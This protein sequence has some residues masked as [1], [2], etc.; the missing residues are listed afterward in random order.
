MSADKSSFP[1]SG[2]IALAGVIA[3]GL[4]V[5]LARAPYPVSR[6]EFRAY[7]PL[8]VMAGSALV[9]LVALWWWHRHVGSS[10][11]LL[12]WTRRLNRNDGVASA[13]QIWRVAGRRAMRKKMTILRPSLKE[14]PWWRRMLVPTRELASPVARV[15]WVRVWSPIED[16][17]LRVGG[18]RSGKSGEMAGRIADAPG[19]AIVTSTRTDL[20]ELTSALRAE[21]GPV[22]VFN[23]AGLAGLESTITFDPL[24]GCKYATTAND[25]AA[26]LLA[27]ASAPGAGGDREFWSDQA[28][29]TL[30]ALLHAAALDGLSMQDVLGWV[31]DPDAGAAEITRALRRSEVKSFEPA[32]VQFLNTNDRTRSSICATI[33]PALGWLTNATAAAAAA[34]GNVFDVERLIAERGTVYMLGAEE[35]QTAPLVTAL[36][37]HIAREGRR[38]AANQPG[39]RLDPPLSLELD[40]AAIISPIP[41]P[42]LTADMGGRNVRINIAVQSRA[43]LRDRWGDNGAAAIMNN[44]ALLLVFGG[45]KD[46]DDLKSYALLAGERDEDVHTWDEDGKVASTTVRKVPVLPPA[47]IAQLP[48][49]HVLI[50]QRGM[51]PAV[52]IVQMGWTRRDI[53]A[54]N[55]RAQRAGLRA[56][57]AA[58]IRAVELLDLNVPPMPEIEGRPPNGRTIDGRPGDVGEHSSGMQRPDRDD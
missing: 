47:Q 56:E 53:K 7:W 31:A 36:T 4:G 23:P 39:G 40:E 32:A 46:D 44:T 35:A 29:R 20:L 1:V 3:I 9:G 14:L 15:G 16:V 33:M 25:R 26:D 22:W 12:R 28:R 21:K 52:G 8:M 38:I 57:E 43:Q 37:A 5:L 17:T 45:M 19:A 13:F 49:R 58:R 50:I 6:L 24:M 42:R 48:A 54:A 18:P 41:L 34:K 30:A 51:P 11:R 2:G 55:K 10:G 27:G